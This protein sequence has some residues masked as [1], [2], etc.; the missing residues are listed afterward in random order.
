MKT[1]VRRGIFE[2]NSSSVHSLTMCTA[3]DYDKWKRGE[4]L[5]DRYNEEL[6]SAEGVSDNSRHL[7]MEEFY[8]YYDDDEC[9]YE[10]FTQG[11]VT[12]TGE[13]VVAFGYYG[14]NR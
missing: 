4:L 13:E 12:P 10:T 8:A 11:F 5:Y 1:Q 14:E 7:N 6:V 3:D 9:C 2:T